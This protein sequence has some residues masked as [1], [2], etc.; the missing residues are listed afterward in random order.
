MWPSISSRGPGPEPTIPT[1]L[2]ASSMLT[3]VKPAARMA[4][5]T[6]RTAA[7]SSPDTLGVIA[8]ERASGS[9]AAIPAGP[10]GVTVDIGAKL[11]AACGR[12]VSGS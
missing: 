2:P 3:S 12:T 4:S 9:D 5:T 7:S 10:V 6:R 11:Y 1:A 8:S